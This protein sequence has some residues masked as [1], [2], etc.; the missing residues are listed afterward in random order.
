VRGAGS[1]GGRGAGG[2]QRGVG[3]AGRG[4]GGQVG[5]AGFLVGLTVLSLLAAVA[6]EQFE[7]PGSPMSSAISTPAVERLA[8]G[9]REQTLLHY[10]LEVRQENAWPGTANI[11]T[12]VEIA[13]QLQAIA[14]TMPRKRSI[15]GRLE[16]T[17]LTGRAT[18]AG[19][20]CSTAGGFA[21]SG[22]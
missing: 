1:A 15:K 10:I 22:G 17:R 7:P 18:G 5:A 9:P 12:L 16:Q 2:S 11:G 6:E 14:A 4:G 21:A 3:T 8:L 20:F 13:G 19:C